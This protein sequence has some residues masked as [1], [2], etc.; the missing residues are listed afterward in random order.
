MLAPE[1][2]SQLSRPVRMR[3]ELRSAAVDAAFSAGGVAG[4]FAVLAPKYPALTIGVAVTLGPAV[5]A[6]R[7]VYQKWKE[8][9]NADRPEG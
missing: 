1:R 8:V 6:T 7:V 4:A 5:R 3:Q 2:D 9:R